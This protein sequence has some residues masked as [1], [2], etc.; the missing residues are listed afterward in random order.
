MADEEVK[1]L[2]DQ[3]E[4]SEDESGGEEGSEEE[5]TEGG[6]DEEEE[7]PKPVSRKGKSKQSLVASNTSK[8]AQAAT[9]SSRLKV[10]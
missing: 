9:Q 5:G 3:E 6:S 8:K 1:E 7:P 2:G 10:C 4:V